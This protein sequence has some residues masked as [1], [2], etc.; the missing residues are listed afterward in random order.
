[1]ETREYKANKEK[2]RQLA[3]KKVAVRRRNS[4]T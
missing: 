3:E 1:M 2:G 4:V